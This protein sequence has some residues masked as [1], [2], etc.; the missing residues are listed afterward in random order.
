LPYRVIIR[1]KTLSRTRNMP[2]LY[3]YQIDSAAKQANRAQNIDK[4][5]FLLYNQACTWFSLETRGLRKSSKE[6]R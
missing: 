1:S 5:G 6:G 2:S 3:Y 4:T